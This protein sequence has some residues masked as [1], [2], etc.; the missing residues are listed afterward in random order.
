MYKSR[1]KPRVY[2]QQRWRS[3]SRDPQLYYLLPSL[4]SSASSITAP[5]SLLSCSP[6]SKR[7]GGGDSSDAWGLWRKK[8]KSWR[9][10]RGPSPIYLH[11]Y[12]TV[13][14]HTFCSQVC[15]LNQSPKGYI[16]LSKSQSLSMIIKVPNSKTIQ[17]SRAPIGKNIQD[18]DKEMNVDDL[19]SLVASSEKGNT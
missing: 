16:I 17:Y 19:F 1:G 14:N 3:G 4:L 9:N 13:L 12:E 6:H 2:C 18:V 15:C 11:T 10:S 5:G 7:L 8:W